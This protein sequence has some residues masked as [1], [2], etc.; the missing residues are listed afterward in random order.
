MIYW[1]TKIF[2][3]YFEY[4]G[5]LE[6]LRR[7]K[8]PKKN[9]IKLTS[10]L[11]KEI[12]S[13]NNGQLTIHGLFGFWLVLFEERRKADKTLVWCPNIVDKKSKNEGQLLIIIFVY[14]IGK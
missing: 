8:S 11:K 2:A 13:I 6:F 4:I 10:V 5:C 1:Y 7:K 3:V 14:E 12:Y 9:P